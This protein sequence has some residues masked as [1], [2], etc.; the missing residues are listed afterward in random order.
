MGVSPEHSLPKDIYIYID[1]LLLVSQVVPILISPN[2]ML[3]STAAVFFK[4]IKS[5]DRERYKKDIEARGR[6]REK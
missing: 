3:I 2:R 1:V 4:E 5:Y 6:D